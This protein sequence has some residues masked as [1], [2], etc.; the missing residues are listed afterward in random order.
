MIG[1]TILEI[2]FICM[3]IIAFIIAVIHDTRRRK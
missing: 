1:V 3:V 2:A